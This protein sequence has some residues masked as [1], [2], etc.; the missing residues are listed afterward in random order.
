MATE[1]LNR[2]VCLEE[3]AEILGSSEEFVEK[4]CLGGS[5]G[6]TIQDGAYIIRFGDLMYQQL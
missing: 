5:L 4:Q 6:F 2:M 3:A 1:D